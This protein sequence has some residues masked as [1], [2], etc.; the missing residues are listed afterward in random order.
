[1]F[2]RASESCSK[3]LNGKKRIQSTEKFQGNSDFQAYPWESHGK[4]RMGWDGTGQA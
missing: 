1:L 3:S 2:F 4:R